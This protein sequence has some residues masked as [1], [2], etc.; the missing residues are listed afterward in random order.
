MTLREDYDEKVS[1]LERLAT[2]LKVA[3]EQ[4]FAD[5]DID[6]LGVTYRIKT[7]ESFEEKIGRK[8]YRRPFVD[9]PDLCGL[10]AVV[11]FPS[12][13]ARI[14]QIIRA[15]FKV[16]EVVNQSTKLYENQFGYRS[17][18]YIVSLKQK[19][20]NAPNYRG[21]KG[22]RAEI[23]V[24]T[25]L[26]HAWAKLSRHLAYKSAEQ[27]PVE[28][29]RRIFQLSALFEMADEEFDHLRQQKAEL[30]A[31]LLSSAA[32]SK[33]GFDLSQPLNLDTLQAYLNYRFPDRAPSE[34][35]AS[36]LVDELKL[37]EITL[38]KL[39]AAI[40]ATAIAVE[41]HE[42]QLFPERN[43]PAWSQVGAVR[44]VLSLTSENYWESQRSTAVDVYRGL[45]ETYRA[46]AG[47]RA[48]SF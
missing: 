27:A 32:S 15:E 48:R 46:A 26:M 37:F 16:Q 17:N 22:L 36:S 6:V 9:T 34:D 38:S 19:W 18:H 25:I 1:L 8:K 14:D 42:P 47:R 44:H 12:D 28:F 39:D 43:R 33:R 41:E 7:F 45:V 40:N 20:L 2:N 5:A 4:F 35:G 30:Q 11:F 10:R 13:L 31:A 29:R 21:L 24:R 23:Q 3:L